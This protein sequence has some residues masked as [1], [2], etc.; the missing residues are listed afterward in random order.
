MSG[1]SG[2]EVQSCGCPVSGHGAGC[3]VSGQG[4]G[5]GCPVSGHK[6]G[7]PVSGHGSCPTCGGSGMIVDP[8]ANAPDVWFADLQNAIREVKLETMK[9]K[10]QKAIGPQIEKAVDAAWEAGGAVWQSLMAQSQAA[11]AMEDLRERIRKI[12][13]EK[14]K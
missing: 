7:C 13:S 6:A 8:F 4:A 9:Q 2:C 14:P 10:V 12:F 5:C 11:M 3:P 1:T